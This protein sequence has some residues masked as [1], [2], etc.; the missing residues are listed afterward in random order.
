MN[1]N[2]KIKK[3]KSICKKDFRVKTINGDVIEILTDDHT[4]HYDQNGNI[5]EEKHRKWSDDQSEYTIESTSYIY[6]KEGKIAEM[7]ERNGDSQ[8]PLTDEYTYKKIY[9]YDDKGKL[10]ELAYYDMEGNPQKK[11]L[12]Q[13][14]EQ[15]REI[16]QTYYE[17]YKSKD[18][19]IKEYLWNTTTTKYDEKSDSVE[20]IYD[21]GISN[22]K[23]TT[24]YD[25]NRNMIEEICECSYDRE[26]E[27]YKYEYNEHGEIIKVYKEYFKNEILLETEITKYDNGNSI[28]FITQEYD[29][30]GSETDNTKS[31]YTNDEYGNMIKRAHYINGK[32]T[33]ITRAE[34]EYYD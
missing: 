2:N 30:N 6:N 33:S 5:L 31:V 34:I 4:T 10:V 25:E 13:Y 32:L 21:R 11:Y 18:G 23:I 7:Y 14:D 17:Y 29:E 12:H 19:E 9:S 28:E 20:T 27:I 15:K 24:K 26:N 8:H 16:K 1:K 3:I 22:M